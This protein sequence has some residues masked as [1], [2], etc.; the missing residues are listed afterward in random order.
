MGEEAVMDATEVIRHQNGS[1]N[2][3]SLEFD[4]YPLNGYYFGSTNAIPFKDETLADRIQRKKSNYAAHGIRNCV[5][6]VMLV[7]LF[8]H[9]HL[10]LLQERNS[11]F[12][13]PGGRLRPGESDIDGLKR[14]LAS[15]L[16]VGENGDGAEWEV[17]ECLGM[18]W[19]P[20]FETLLY[21]YLPPNVK[22]PKECTKL[23]LVKLPGSR[24][25]IV[26]K[27][28]KLLAVPLC[29]IPENHKTY[30]TIISGVPQLLSKFS[31]NMIGLE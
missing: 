16:Y 3:Q 24:K 26:P 4:I 23:Y 28:H 27:N 25:F 21:P 22:S 9:P 6:A 17:G 13:L 2:H 19:R 8:K 30:G 12:K 18:W 5:E 11:I 10:L 31:F 15:K 1:S 7:E 29:Q 20:D 14:K